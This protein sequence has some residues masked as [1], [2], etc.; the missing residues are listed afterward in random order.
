MNA[1]TAMK[2]LRASCRFSNEICSILEHPELALVL[3]HSGI[4]AGLR[5]ALV[6]MQAFVDALDETKRAA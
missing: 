4:S 3:K 2:A 6:D 5:Q 1:K